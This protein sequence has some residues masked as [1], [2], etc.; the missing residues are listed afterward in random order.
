M[1]AFDWK[2]LSSTDKVISVTALI[3][4]IG[5]FLPW[6]GVSSPFGSASSDGFSS[7]YGILGALLIIAA[8]V[9]LVFLRSGSNMPKTSYGPGVLVLGASA[10]GAVIVILKWVTLP[11][12]SGAYAAYSYGPRFGIFIVLIAGVVQAFFA[13]RLFRSTGEA[14][15]W[16]NKS[17]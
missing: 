16:A 14:V 15:H 10:L 3:T 11:R 8:G 4:L 5:L 7:G 6:Y 2:K 13:L 12:G 9:Y 17:S 1:A